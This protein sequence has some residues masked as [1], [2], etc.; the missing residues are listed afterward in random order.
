[1]TNPYRGVCFTGAYLISPLP[2]VLHQLS[3]SSEDRGRSPIPMKTRLVAVSLLPQVYVCV[4]VYIYVC[5]YVCSI[6]KATDCISSW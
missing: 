3:L 2:S 6:F 5:M 4:Y 1:M